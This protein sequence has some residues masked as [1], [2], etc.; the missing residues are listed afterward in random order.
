MP[1]KIRQLIADLKDAG[2]ADR[3]GKGSHRNFEHRSG[4]RV[5]LSGNAGDDAH[6]YQE[7]QVKKAIEQSR[8]VEP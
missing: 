6:H 4:Q 5:T 3:G 8:T 7:K 2:F 1:R